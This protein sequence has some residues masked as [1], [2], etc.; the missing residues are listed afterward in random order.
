VAVLYQ[1]VD[2]SICFPFIHSGNRPG[3]SVKL[4]QRIC[5]FL[6]VVSYSRQYQFIDFFRTVTVQEVLDSVNFT[7]GYFDNGSRPAS[8][9]VSDLENLKEKNFS[10][11][12]MESHFTQ[13]DHSRRGLS[14]KSPSLRLWTSK[15]RRVLL[16][17][18]RGNVRSATAQNPGPV[19]EP[20][21][22]MLVKV[23]PAAAL[24]SVWRERDLASS[25]R[26]S[27]SRWN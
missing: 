5:S 13:D 3:L 20:S 11:S 9:D 22:Q 15:T 12:T 4:W 25:V 19:D 8:E 21:F 1:R 17:K 2:H 6:S 26:N 14:H 10:Q 23:P 27:V 16:R 24:S 18:E 7:P